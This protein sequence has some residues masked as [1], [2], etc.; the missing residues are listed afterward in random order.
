MR[1][2]TMHFYRIV[3]FHTQGRF[4][5]SLSVRVSDSVH[6]LMY[7]RKKLQTNL[8]TKYTALCQ[9]SPQDITHF[10][11]VL[12]FYIRGNF[13]LA[14]CPRKK[15]LSEI[16]LS[17]PSLIHPLSPHMPLSTSKYNPNTNSSQN[18]PLFPSLGLGLGLVLGLGLGLRLGLRSNYTLARNRYISLHTTTRVAYY[19]YLYVIYKY[20]QTN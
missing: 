6:P 18:I 9:H 11:I 8:V 17:Q 7:S 16:K 3:Q 14:C 1:V 5:A 15:M 12:Q 20:Y 19:F 2:L 13:A 4:C 10:Y